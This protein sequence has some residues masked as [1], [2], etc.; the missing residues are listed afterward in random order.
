MKNGPH[1]VQQDLRNDMY[2]LTSLQS[3]SYYEDNVDRGHAIREKC[4]LIQDLVQS[5]QR[6]E[7]EREQARQYREK[8]NPGSTYK[9]GSQGSGYDSYGGG[10]GGMNPP[11]SMGS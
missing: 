3:F 7:T 5:P 8:F 6:L 2:K 4:I 1:R 10:G 9:Q 11:T